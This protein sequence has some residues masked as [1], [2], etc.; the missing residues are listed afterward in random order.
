[1]SVEQTAP[2]IIITQEEI[3]K[4]VLLLRSRDKGSSFASFFCDNLPKRNQMILQK[5]LTA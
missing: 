1:M 4:R 2:K 3:V 5:H